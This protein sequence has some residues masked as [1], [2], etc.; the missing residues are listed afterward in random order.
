[1]GTD[2]YFSFLLYSAVFLSRSLGVA[3][4]LWT[5][6]RSVAFWTVF[7]IQPTEKLNTTRRIAVWQRFCVFCYV[8]NVLNV[9]IM[10]VLCSWLHT[11]AMDSMQ[12]NIQNQNLGPVNLWGGI[13]RR[14]SLNTAISRPADNTLVSEMT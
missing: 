4:S 9:H 13:F 5:L 6:V 11:V 12:D 3:Q 8:E 1:V 10:R 2:R 14:N 7:V